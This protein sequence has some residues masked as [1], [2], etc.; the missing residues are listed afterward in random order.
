MAIKRMKIMSGYDDVPMMQ[1]PI[2]NPG[3]DNGPGFDAPEMKDGLTDET[4][5]K[6]RTPIEV[7]LARLYARRNGNAATFPNSTYTGTRV[8]PSDINTDVEDNLYSIQDF[9]ESAPYF[10]NSALTRLLGKARS[11]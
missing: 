4:S 6:T 8:L 9:K 5:D 10:A 7:R 1:H 3:L 2:N 11:K